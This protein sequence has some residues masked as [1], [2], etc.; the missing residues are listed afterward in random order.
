MRRA[1]V[2]MLALFVP[3]AHAADEP[4]RLLSSGTQLYLRWDGY[5][6][7]R[8]SYRQT[9]LGQVFAGD[10]GRSLDMIGELIENAIKSELLG[11]PLLEGVPP[12]ELSRRYADWVEA[13][14]LPDLIAQHGVI[15]GGEMR[16][17]SPLQELIPLLGGADPATALIP[18]AYFTVIIPD[19]GD[20][21]APAFAAMRLLAEPEGLT[22]NQMEVT[23]RVVMVVSFGPDPSLGSMCC[24][25][26]GPHLI[27]VSANADPARIVARVSE[28]GE[29]I[30]TSTHYQKVVAFDEFPTDVRGFVDV[31]APVRLA[32][33]LSKGLAPDVWTTVERIG[34]T[35]VDRA[36]L[37]SGFDGAA[38]RSAFELEFNEQRRGIRNL[39]GDA[40]LTLADLPPLPPDASRW[41]AMRVNSE[42]IYDI[43]LDATAAGLAVDDN[44]S[45]ELD[46]LRDEAAESYDQFL[47][48]RVRDELLSA[49]GDTL[50]TYHST[51]EGFSNFGQALAIS[52]KDEAK[53][54]RIFDRLPRL[55][56]F[57]AFG[58]EVRPRV[59]TYHGIEIRQLSGFE[60]FAPCYA[61]CDGWLIIA[62]YPQPVHGFILRSEGKLPT[63]Q[64][65]EQT[66]QRFASMADGA[67]VL[68]YCDPTSSV[69]FVLSFLPPILGALSASPFSGVS[70]EIH[71]GLVPNAHDVCEPLFPNV[72]C[73][74]D[75][76]NVW[77]WDSADS[78]YIPP[79]FT[80]PDL[81]FFFGL[82]GF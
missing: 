58:N 40:P 73:L 80:P 22:V 39:F 60:I 50:V 68:H 78:L 7:H 54:R 13:R 64:P 76:G 36:M 23:D 48:F 34:L 46:A 62:A 55:A 37:W 71:P 33:N 53:L 28:A 42:A 44:R 14:R 77:R 10:A 27:L 2:V 47:G 69:K 31:S 24:W 41:T 20:D 11:D 12:D 30:L 21:P 74:R 63:W 6:A 15:L 9:A 29:G 70:P 81:V 75:D 16:G 82:A 3:V 32:Y 67:V 38:K 5:T 79:E 35:D 25:A 26:E 8:D 19:A 72:T 59:Y 66:A 1:A 4:E 61:I 56:N 65:D 45:G 51:G 17:P 18:K 57:L 43:I 49:L 52:V